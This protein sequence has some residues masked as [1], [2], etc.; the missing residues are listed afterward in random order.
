MSTPAWKPLPSA[1]RITTCTEGSRPAPRISS[2]SW[3]HPATGSAL[4]GGLSIVTI[5]IGPCRSLRIMRATQYSCGTAGTC[6]GLGE[7]RETVGPVHLAR[8]RD[9][10]SL[11]GVA[12]H[13]CD[14]V[15][16]RTE[17]HRDPCVRCE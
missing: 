5:A 14:G 10:G 15:L 7:A 11:R 13:A 8:A 17:R 3:Y 4:T 2:A 1:R 9:R 12:R 16:G 6:V